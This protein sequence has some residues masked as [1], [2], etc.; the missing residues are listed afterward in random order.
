M[1]SNARSV[2]RRIQAE[3]SF[4]FIF[5]TVVSR[6]ALSIWQCFRGRIFCGKTFGFSAQTIASVACQQKRRE[7]AASS[8]FVDKSCEERRPRLNESTFVNFITPSDLL[9]TSDRLI[10][11]RRFIDGSSRKSESLIDAII[12]PCVEK[13]GTASTCLERQ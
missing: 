7:N 3:M 11:S 10:N 13:L 9:H 2:V 4:I 12:I 1:E 6:T 8:D 5:P